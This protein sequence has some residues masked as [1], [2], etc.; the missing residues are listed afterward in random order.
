[1]QTA[2]LFQDGYT[3]IMSDSRVLLLGCIQSL[4]E[5]CMYIFVFLW[6]PVLTSGN[7]T[8][9]DEQDPPL[10]MA[11]SAFMVCIMIGSSIFSAQIAG[12]FEKKA[13]S[14]GHIK[15]TLTASHVL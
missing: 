15:P 10:G 2:I 5:A 9:S 11:F 6:T 13:F 8:K 7:G 1:M 14:V 4:V 12:K 3:Y